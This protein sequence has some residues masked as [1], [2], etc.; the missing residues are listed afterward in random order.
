M[1]PARQTMVGEV[2]PS[3]CAD[4]SSSLE[5]LDRDGTYLPEYKTYRLVTFSIAP[6][7][8]PTKGAQDRRKAERLAEH[9]EKQ[10]R[11]GTLP[12]E[13]NPINLADWRKQTLQPAGNVAAA[14]K[15][16]NDAVAATRWLDIKIT[17]AD[18]GWLSPTPDTAMAR[19]LRGVGPGE[20]S[21]TQKIGLLHNLYLVMQTR[22]PDAQQLKSQPLE[23]RVLAFQAELARLRE[24]QRQLLIGQGAIVYQF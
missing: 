6:I 23:T 4:T 24:Q 11:A 13:P 21:R 9:V 20:F 2:P 18:A 1:L 16:L 10:L 7:I 15:Q 5:T 22:M 3:A 8:D 17:V 12:T 19:L 14:V